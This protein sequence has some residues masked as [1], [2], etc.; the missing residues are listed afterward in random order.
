MHKR[1]IAYTLAL[2]LLLSAAYLPVTAILQGKNDEMQRSEIRSEQESVAGAVQTI[3]GQKTARL[4]SDLLY[5]TDTLRLCG[6]ADGYG[7][8]KEQWIAFSNRK[9]IYDQIRYLDNDGDEVVRV[10]YGSGG[11]RAVPRNQLQNNANRSYFKD[12]MALGKNQ[13]YVSKMDLNVENGRIEQ[14]VK[15]MIRLAMRCYGEDG[16]PQGIVVLNYY[17]DDILSQI[18]KVAA[19]SRGDVCLLNAAGYW[20]F[21]SQDSSHAWA[22]MYESRVR[23]SFALRYPEEWAAMAGDRQGGFTADDGYFYYVRVFAGNEL[24]GGSTGYSVR[25]GDGDFTVVCHVPADT[26]GGLFARTAA[27]T[28]AVAARRNG[29]VFLL[30][31][32]LSF[33]LSF[34]LVNKRSERARIRY[35]SEYD[36]MTGIC[37]R[38]AG[39]EKLQRLCQESR[40][41]GKPLSL[42]FIDINGL[43]EVNDHLG[44]EA[45]DE[46]ILAV[47]SAIRSCIREGDVLARLGGDEFLAVFSGMDEAQAEAVWQR[48]AARMDEIN[49][50][51]NRAY[52]VSASHGIETVNTAGPDYI[53]NAVNRADARMYEEKRRIKRN[54]SVIRAA[55]GGAPAGP[56]GDESECPE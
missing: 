5:I 42:C 55:G 10:N 34:Y 18:G 50:G 20:L 51:E 49:A 45:G 6:S 9:Q 17:A 14:P 24:F 38:R 16:T 46:L 53:D 48:V 29:A 52:L 28:V 23:D 1:L 56:E 12:T 19:S 8:V 22:F 39:F 30:L 36:A 26:D 15:P 47:V 44:H 21:D 35:F 25:L 3:L 43:K 37:N 27:G 13:I 40:R 7:A 4:I 11:A 32:L 2:F 41:T 54:L 33:T 31:L